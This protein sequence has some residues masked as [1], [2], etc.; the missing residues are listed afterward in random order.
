MRHVEDSY[1]WAQEG[2]VKTGPQ[3]PDVP[4]DPNPLP[5][6]RPYTGG[7]NSAC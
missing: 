2:D 6:R 3:P 5:L 7:A 1:A 4:R